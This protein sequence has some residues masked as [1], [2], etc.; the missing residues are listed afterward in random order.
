MSDEASCALR[1]S[2]ARCVREQE[3]EVRALASTIYSDERFA[4]VHQDGL[5]CDVARRVRQQEDGRRRWV[6]RVSKTPH[7]NPASMTRQVTADS[8]LHDVRTL[9][10][11]SRLKD[12]RQGRSGTYR[13]DANPV[14][15]EFEGQHPGQLQGRSLGVALA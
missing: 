3:C 10:P 12:G 7:R 14:G 11:Q 1:F 8:L 9:G 5:A 15:C 6:D 13:I 4:T 2:L